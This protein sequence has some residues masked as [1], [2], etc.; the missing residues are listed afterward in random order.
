MGNTLVV[1]DMQPFFTASARPGLVDRIAARVRRHHEC[2]DAVVVLETLVEGLDH[3]VENSTHADILNS[4]GFG[5]DP[6]GGTA[7]PDGHAILTYKEQ[8]DGSHAVIKA[9]RLL[10][11]RLEPHKFIVCG[12]NTD[13]CVLDTA[14]GL[15]R[16]VPNSSVVLPVWCCACQSDRKR[17]EDKGIHASALLIEVFCK[18]WQGRAT[19]VWGADE[20]G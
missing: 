17:E 5:P 7:T 9:V 11:P 8:D 19:R 15:L 6:V 20:I 1:V 3:R 14:R 12:V 2:G 16:S 4:A 13:A 18:D 10:A